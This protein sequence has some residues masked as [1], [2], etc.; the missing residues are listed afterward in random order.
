MAMA[1]FDW[2]ERKNHENQKK[3]G[4]SFDLAQL[5]FTDPGRVIAEDLAHAQSEKRYYCFGRVGYGVLTVR[6]T[7]RDGII[8]IIGAGYWRRGK[9]I[10]EEQS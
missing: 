4:V 8:R 2:D 6:F 5:A 9:K 3:H 1:R 10:Y 7:Y